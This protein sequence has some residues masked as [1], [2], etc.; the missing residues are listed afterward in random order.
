MKAKFLIRNL[1]NTSPLINCPVGA[2]TVSGYSM[3]Q[4]QVGVDAVYASSTENSVK[5]SQ[6]QKRHLLEQSILLNRVRHLVCLYLR[7][8]EQRP[9]LTKAITRCYIKSEATVAVATLPPMNI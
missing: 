3:Q 7:N 4:A 9:I 1:G 2:C 5:W 6:G 8:L